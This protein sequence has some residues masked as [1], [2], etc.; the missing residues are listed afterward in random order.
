MKARLGSR[1]PKGPRP[2]Q[3]VRRRDVRQSLGRLASLLLLFAVL[4]IVGMV[5]FEGLTVFEALWLT[6]TT[7][8]T[9]GYGDYSANTGL[10]RLSTILFVFL[11][12]IWVAF[13]TAA[14]WFDYRADRRERMRL[15]RWRWNMR[16]HILILNVP[17]RD[18]T[19]YLTRLVNEFHASRRYAG[20]TVQLV[21]RCYENGMPDALTEAGVIHTAGEPWDPEALRAASA[22]DADLIVVLAASDID[23]GTDGRTLDIVD[24]LRS[25]GA[26][27]RI[28]AECVADDNRPRFL[29]FGAN[30]V[31]R[32]LRG[33]PEMIVRAS[34][35]PG[36]EKI[37][38]DLFTSDRDECWR[39]NVHVK[40]ITW[41][42]VVTV[43]V[44]EDVGVPIAYRA[45]SGGQ[46]GVNPPPHTEIDADKLFVLVREG[47]AQ[48]DEHVENLLR[49]RGLKTS[50]RGS[51]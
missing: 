41:A 23:P 39:Y 7:L 4:H 47:N 31:V 40:G 48:P 1:T 34:A 6:L 14:T 29:R 20:R 10:G 3:R 42:E 30:T 32:P 43:L 13:Q 5:A 28:V 38:E 45:R 26:H 46:I 2:L 9:V 17:G 16:D 37:L 50:G 33:Y 18:P 35:A 15:G 49:R 8:T 11:G 12:G 27:G 44:R 25:M 19:P 51:A 22:V 36:S 24:R 21:C